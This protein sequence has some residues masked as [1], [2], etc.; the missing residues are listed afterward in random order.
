MPVEGDF[1]FLLPCTFMGITLWWSEGLLLT[2]DVPEHLANQLHH[3]IRQIGSRL[4]V[5]VLP[6]SHEGSRL[7]TWGLSISTAVL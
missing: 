5:F 3:I 6:K 4:V 1:A 7:E 2:T